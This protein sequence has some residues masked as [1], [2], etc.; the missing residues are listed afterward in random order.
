LLRASLSANSRAEFFFDNQEVSERIITKPS[1]N[2]D[3]IF[4]FDVVVG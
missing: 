2:E 3:K 4:C 1:L